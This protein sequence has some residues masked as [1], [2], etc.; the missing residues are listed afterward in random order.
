MNQQLQKVGC[1]VPVACAPCVENVKGGFDP[2]GG[3]LICQNHIWGK[4]R[5][6]ATLT[7]EMVHAFDHCRFQFDINNLKQVACA[8]VCFSS[9]RLQGRVADGRYG[10][11]RCLESVGF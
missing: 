5:T 2:N 7:H 8:E 6:E 10:R 1:P 11:M 4:R 9:P 3:I